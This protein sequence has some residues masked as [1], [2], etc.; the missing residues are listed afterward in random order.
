MGQSREKLG[1]GVWEI[2]GHRSSR[3][4]VYRGREN[5]RAG[6][7][8][9]SAT[10]SYSP[11]RHSRSVTDGATVMASLLFFPPNESPRAVV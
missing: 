7:A 8:S 11:K 4:E 6:R 5:H 3:V 9:M 10:A 1:P 2:D